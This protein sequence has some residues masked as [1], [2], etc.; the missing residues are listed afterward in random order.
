MTRF[1]PHNRQEMC[2]IASHRAASVTA[3]ELTNVLR[4]LG[5]HVLHG[6][7]VDQGGAFRRPPR[8]CRPPARAGWARSRGSHQPLPPV[9]PGEG[10]GDEDT[11]GEGDNQIALIGLKLPIDHQAVAGAEGRGEG[12]VIHRHQQVAV[13]SPPVPRRAARSAAR[14][15]GSSSAARCRA[16]PRHDGAAV[17][18]ARSP[19]VPRSRA[20]VSSVQSRP[21]PCRTSAP[22]VA[23]A[24]GPSFRSLFGVHQPKS[25]HSVLISA[26][27]AD[28]PSGRASVPDRPATTVAPRDPEG[29][30]IA[31]ILGLNS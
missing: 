5:R 16:A 6:T 23:S 25:V 10:A 21:Y 26:D 19:A 30:T 31:R 18:R 20:R 12:I 27:S 11:T 15:S 3:R 13:P 14:D 29:K 2:P 4:A 8:G 24:D 7:A 1:P 22:I 17:F 9:L 28:A